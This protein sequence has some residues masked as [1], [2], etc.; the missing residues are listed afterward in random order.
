M[1][2]NGGLMRV[3]TPEAARESRFLARASDAD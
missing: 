3:R 1:N 2:A